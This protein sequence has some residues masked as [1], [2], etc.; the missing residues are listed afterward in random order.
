MQCII[1]S[2]TKNWFH[3]QIGCNKGK[4]RGHFIGER[5]KSVK[6]S[7]LDVFFFFFFICSLLPLIGWWM[8]LYFKRSFPPPGW[9]PVEI[10]G[11]DVILLCLFACPRN[12]TNNII[13]RAKGTTTVSEVSSS[14][15]CSA[16]VHH[17]PMQQERLPLHIIDKFDRKRDY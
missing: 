12:N 16:I 3:V 8:D 11:I 17:Q 14:C 2:P 10:E 7:L 5:Y 9:T 6:R 4:W 1:S 15:F 13:P